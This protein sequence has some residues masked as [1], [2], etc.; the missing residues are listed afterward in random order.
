MEGI[1]WV[2]ETASKTFGKRYAWNLICKYV[3]QFTVAC[4]FGE[5]PSVRKIAV[6]LKVCFL[7]I[8]CLIS[9]NIPAMALNSFCNRGCRCKFLGPSVK[10]S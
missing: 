4:G 5:N 8:L 6:L 7:G 3:C 1:Q 9:G 10:A 2:N